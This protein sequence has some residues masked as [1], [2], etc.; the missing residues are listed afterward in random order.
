MI[1]P[2]KNRKIVYQYLFRGECRWGGKGK[3]EQHLA[4]RR[5]KYDGREKVPSH[6]REKEKKPFFPWLR[7]ARP[8]NAR[9]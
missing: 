7:I 8:E 5:K 6:S 2:K 4:L 1:I 9:R 3:V